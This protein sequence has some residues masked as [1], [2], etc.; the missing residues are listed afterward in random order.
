[1]SRSSARYAALMNAEVSD[2]TRVI[3]GHDLERF[4]NAHGV[5]DISCH[6]CGHTS[7]LVHSSESSPS[8]AFIAVNASLFAPQTGTKVLTLECQ[9][10]GT[11]WCISHK[12]IA[13]WLEA[14]PK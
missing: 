2:A 7:W 9:Q 12:K 5:K 14:N 11:L 6:R 3:W 4:N 8:H 13:E 10:C 1:M